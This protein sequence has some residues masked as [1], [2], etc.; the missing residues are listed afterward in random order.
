[1]MMVD[2][3]VKNAKVKNV[4]AKIKN[5]PNKILVDYYFKNIEIIKINNGKKNFL[6]I[7]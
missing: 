5:V 6:F 2:E 1:M 3:K 7:E 4:K